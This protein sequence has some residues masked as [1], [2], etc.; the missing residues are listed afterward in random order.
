MKNLMNSSSE[1]TIGLPVRPGVVLGRRYSVARVLGVGG[2]GVVFLARDLTTKRFV[3]L[4][5]FRDEFVTDP[6]RRRAFEREALL[7]LML[8]RHR[9]IVEVTVMEYIQS[10]AD[11]R[12]SLFDYL[13]DSSRR[14]AKEQVT[15]WAI[16]FCLG[17]EYANS[18]GLQSHGDIK[19]GNILVTPQGDLKI[20]D[21]GLARASQ[22]PG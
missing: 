16:E 15:K 19:P 14:L 5:T 9:S 4:K 6:Q 10:G 13:K 21:F 17:M 8:G 20:A 2:C 3:A 7:W 18:H 12:V 1:N 22:S 11:G